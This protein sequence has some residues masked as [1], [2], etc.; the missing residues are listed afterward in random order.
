MS[1]KLYLVETISTFRIRYVVEA[2]EEG[3]AED[4]VTMSDADFYEFSQKHIDESI[5][6]TRELS[7]IEY[8]DLFDKDN[9]YLSKWDDESK[10]KFINKINYDEDD[11]N[12]NLPPT[13]CEFDE[14]EEAMKNV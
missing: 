12:V 2:K 9:E 8:L 1:K 10:M 4:E 13:E 3:H 7:R 11:G 5:T 6:S 14:I